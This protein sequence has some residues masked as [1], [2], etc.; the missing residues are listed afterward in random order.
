MSEQQ[1]PT[2]ASRRAQ[3]SAEIPVTQ[4]TEIPEASDQHQAIPTGSASNRQPTQTRRRSGVMIAVLCGLVGFAIVL[5]VRQTT[6]DQLST[7][8]QDDLIRLLEDVTTRSEQLEAEV[9]R[10][11]GIRGD[12]VSGTDQQ[13]A[14][15][16]V[17][18]QRATIEGILSGR[19]PAQGSG[20][21]IEISD[22]FHGVRAT[23]L[24]N[25]LE[26]LRNAGA[27]VVQVND[28]RVTASTAFTDGG[29][30]VFLDGNVLPRD[31]T[32]R[33]IGDPGTLER[34]LEIPGGALPR[35]RSTGATAATTP[36]ELVVV[37]AV[38][39]LREAQ[40][41]RPVVDAA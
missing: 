35:I 19:L 10:L 18:R 15:F 40:F 37:D 13:E 34:A 24:V 28:F 7:L 30:N 17:A 22:P 27:E 5:Q 32:W 16:E 26:E 4:T 39:R 9:A 33:V 12:L 38:A 23:D 3:L 20:I 1:L 41:A 31:L 11:E 6:T 21:E 36:Q 25:L 14:A 2:R 8:R 29:G